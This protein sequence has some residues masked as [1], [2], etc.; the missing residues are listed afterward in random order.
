M[1]EKELSPWDKH[2]R[3]LVW[4][5]LGGQGQDG[6]RLDCISLQHTDWPP[7]EAVREMYPQYEGTQGK[8]ASVLIS[9]SVPRG[10][11]V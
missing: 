11:L 2:R 4:A 9:I 1:G 7:R 6:G 5:G 3:G 8:Q 10:T